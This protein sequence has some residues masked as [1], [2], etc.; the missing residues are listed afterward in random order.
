ML[1]SYTFSNFQSFLEPTRISTTVSE[2]V[3]PSD[4]LT[5]S[6]TGE[7]VNKVIAVMGANGSGK[8]TL[9]K[10]LVF[11]DWF[12]SHSFSQA[13][14]ATIPFTPHF[15]ATN[16]A[17]EFS[18]TAIYKGQVWKYVLRC[19]PDR[20]IHEALYVKKERFKY[21]FVRDWEDDNQAYRIKQQDFGF[22]PVEAR[23]VRANASLIS[24][25]AQYGVPL[26]KD[27]A[28][29]GMRSN[30]TA[31]GRQ[32]L[33]QDQVLN[34]AAHFSQLSDQK[35][36]MARLLHDWDLGLS[37]V[38]LE[39]ISVAQP[40]GSN[41]K[42]WLPIGIHQTSAGARR[43]N[44]LLE[45]SGTQAA[46]VLLSHLLP[47]LQNGGIAVIDE[48]ENDLHPHMLEPILG[49]FASHATNPH[50]AQLLFTCHSAEVLNLLHKSQII[51]V[52]KNDNCEST[53]WRLDEMDGVRNDDNFYAK[54]MAGAYGA[55]PRL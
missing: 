42:V 45:S 49:L 11:L 29:S 19:I 17:T 44:F 31:L 33:S 38:E 51:L 13:P 27:M 3:T 46:M 1:L 40:D 12:I 24:T 39:E 8:T 28:S 32:P 52:E 14:E 5:N 20:V 30:I 7:R 41:H 9:L 2:K 26:A 4:W 15:A 18:A 23:K 10:P 54:Y 34:A 22:A 48:F 36:T 21:V 53:A 55:V 25:A 16:E 47:A 50:N 6:P 43:L 35:A 37:N